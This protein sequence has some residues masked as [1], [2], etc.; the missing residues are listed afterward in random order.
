MRSRASVIKLLSLGYTSKFIEDCRASVFKGRRHEIQKEHLLALQELPFAS[1]TTTHT[2]KE[3]PI[4]TFPLT[5]HPCTERLK[6]RV[7]EM[8]LRLAFT[9]NSTLQQQLKHKSITCQQP[10][11][12]VYVVNCSACTK[13]YIGQ[14][15]K[16]AEDRMLEH[17]RGP[18]YTNPSVGA[19]NN[20]NKISGHCMDLLNP[21]KVFQSDC[22]Y[23]RTTVEAALI[24]VAPTVDRNTASASTDNNELVAP[25]IC[26]ATKLNWQKLANCIP[27]FDKRAIPNYKRHLFGN[28]EIVRPHPSQRSQLPGIPVSHRT[29]SRHPSEPNTPTSSSI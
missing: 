19:V 16:H 7:N 27:H 1:N 25:M 9:T 20:H 29:R 22:T 3:E 6:P 13:V 28:H 8:G 17:S 15:G 12:S 23:T 14:T 5:Y 11:G 4:A 2:E 10:K 24:H 21:T 18:T 26:R